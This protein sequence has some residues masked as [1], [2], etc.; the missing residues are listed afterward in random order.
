MSAN[1]QTNVNPNAAN[2]ASSPIA[3]PVA[4]FEIYVQNMDRAKRFYEGVLNTK[5][6]KLASPI[7]EAARPDGSTD[8]MW[9]FPSNQTSYG[10]SGALAK[11]EGVPSGG[12]GTIVYFHCKDCAVEETRAVKHGG[13]IKRSKTSIGPHGA[14][15]LVYDTEGNL[16]GLHSM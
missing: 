7:V 10:T 13:R 9:Q 4:W 12:M 15:S 1:S 2:T 16:F 3:N 11:M 14:I 8:E 6:Q 5:L